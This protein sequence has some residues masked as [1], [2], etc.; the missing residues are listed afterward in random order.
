MTALRA[1]KFVHIREPSK[2]KANPWHPHGNDRWCGRW[3]QE[4]TDGKFVATKGNHEE[5]KRENERKRDRMSFRGRLAPWTAPTRLPVSLCPYLFVSL[6]HSTSSVQKFDNV[7]FAVFLPRNILFRHFPMTLNSNGRSTW[8]IRHV[9]SSP[10]KRP[11]KE[12]E[13]FKLMIAKCMH[14]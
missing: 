4:E 3:N 7:T 2:S 8:T 12:E 6:F 11:M 5:N 9:F 1:L 10:G 14:W 13:N